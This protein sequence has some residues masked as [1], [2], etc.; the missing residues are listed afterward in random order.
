MNV[1]TRKNI[2]MKGMEMETV[3]VVEALGL[4]NKE[5]NNKSATS[6]VHYLSRKYPPK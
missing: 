6:L 1:L 4:I 2:T 5:L 3:L